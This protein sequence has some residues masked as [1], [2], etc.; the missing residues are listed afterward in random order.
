L[1]AKQMLGWVPEI[2]LDQM[3]VEMVSND[4]ELAKRHVLL[5]NYG[6]S[7]EVSKEI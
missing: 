2:T 1:K 5:N 4:L 6:H 3:I 7:V